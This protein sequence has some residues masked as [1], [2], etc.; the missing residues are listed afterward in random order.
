MKKII[1]FILLN[2]ILTFSLSAN[3][4]EK[5][6]FKQDQIKSEFQKILKKH[7]LQSDDVSIVL[8]KEYNG[9]EQVELSISAENPLIPASITKIITAAAVLDQLP[10]DVKFK[11]QILI[12]K[13]KIKNNI[14]KDNIYFKGGGDPS[15][16]SENMWYL[17]NVFTRTGITKIEGDI[18]VDDSLF[19]SVRFDSSRESVRVDRAYDAPVGALSFNWN[20][21]NIFIRPSE[22]EDKAIVVLDPANN[23][24]TLKN[25]VKNAT[26][27]TVL[28]ADREQDKKNKKDVL[29]VSG[30]INKNSKE[31]VIFKNITSPDLWAG[32]NLKSF[33]SQ[34]GIV[35]QGEVQSGIASEN[36]EVVS[37]YE[38]KNIS[39]ILADMNKFSNNYIAEMLTKHLGLSFSR[40]G[41]LENGM[42]KINQ[43]VK[44]LNIPDLQYKLINPSGLTR[45]NRLSSFA[46][47]KVLQAMK[48]DFRHYPELS[49]SLPIS[50]FDGTLKRRLKGTAAEGWVRAKTG[51]LNNVVSLAGYAGRK[52]GS[53]FTFSMIYNGPVDEAQVRNCFDDLLLEVIK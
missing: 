3:S 34:R 4:S 31:Q 32:E 26:S 8:T 33:L 28:L 1:N 12:N 52:D 35:V 27:K 45:D 40:P 17:V 7:K 18:I 14:L 25:N 6:S 48:H 2:S 46:M 42:K 37:E 13:N 51:Y 24:T 22:N 43:Y 5:L 36:L 30:G 49:M 21:V 9:Q 10:Q 11:T 20:S 50:G 41:T 53:H 29:S 16:V 44:N 38:S 15:F 39:Q 47:W 23:Y 19:D